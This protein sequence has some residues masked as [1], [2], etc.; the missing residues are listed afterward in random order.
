MLGQTFLNGI[1]DHLCCIWPALKPDG[2]LKEWRRFALFD[3]YWNKCADAVAD[4]SEIPHF[5]ENEW[6]R[7][8]YRRSR[9]DDPDSSSNE[10]GNRS[11]SRDNE[12]EEESDDRNSRRRSGKNRHT[13]HD[14]RTAQNPPSSTNWNQ[15]PSFYLR[16]SHTHT[17]QSSRRCLNILEGQGTRVLTVQYKRLAR[18]LLLRQIITR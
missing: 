3:G 11:Y 10:S 2:D 9:S 15:E 1:F 5:C 4:Q 18:K 13:E 6:N 17:P 16:M 7:E 12:R 14:S 8:D